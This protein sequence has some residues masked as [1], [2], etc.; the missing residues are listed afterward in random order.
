MIRSDSLPGSFLARFLDTMILLSVG[1]FLLN[2]RLLIALNMH[3]SIAITARG[4]TIRVIMSLAMAPP[5]PLKM[6][7]ALF[8]AFSA[9]FNRFFS[10]F[11]WCAVLMSV[12]VSM[13]V[14]AVLSCCNSISFTWGNFRLS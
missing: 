8:A 12:F 2:I 5:V 11:T 6:P 1:F 10:P 3:R 13:F 7:E 4:G 14:V 9:S